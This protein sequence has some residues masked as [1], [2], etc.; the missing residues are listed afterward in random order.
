MTQ[1]QNCKNSAK[2]RDYE[3]A[4]DNHKNKK[5]VKEVNCA[6]NEATNKQYVL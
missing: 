1:Q 2:E 4:K 3:F 5:F 6:T